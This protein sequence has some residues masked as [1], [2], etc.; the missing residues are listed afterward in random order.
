MAHV[1]LTLACLQA[2]QSM[3]HTAKEVR[4]KEI[5]Q[6]ELQ[7]RGKGEIADSITAMWKELNLA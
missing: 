4:I 3:A 5:V 6:T 2:D 7:K 1:A